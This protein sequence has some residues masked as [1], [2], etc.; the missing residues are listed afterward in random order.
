MSEW[1]PRHLAER[2]DLDAFKAMTAGVPVFDDPALVKRKS[3]DFFWFSPIL[4]EQL[5]HK[6]AD[7]VAQPETEAQVIA[8]ARACTKLRIPLTVRGAGSGTYGQGVPLYGG[9][10]LDMT[11]LDRL[12]WIKPD[13]VRA[14]A[15]HRILHLDQEARKLGVELRMHPSTKRTATIGGYFTGGSGGVGS[16]TYGGLREPGNLVAA[17]VVTM[18]E[19]PRILELRGADAALVNRT[20]GTTGIV[21]EVELPLSPAP[22]WHDIALPFEDKMQAVRFATALAGESAIAK[23][24]VS[25]AHHRIAESFE[26]LEAALAGQNSVLSMVDPAHLEAV[27]ALAHSFGSDIAYDRDSASMEDDPEAVPIYEYSW[28]HATLHA[29]KRDK[30]L[31][32]LQTLFA[33]PD[34]NDKIARMIDIFGDEVMLRLE[35]IRYDGDLAA[36]GAQLIPFRSAERIREII[37][38]HEA[39]DIPVANPHVYT[40]EDGS[41]HK[42]VPGDQ[43][44]FKRVVDPHGLLNPGKMTG[45][46]P[47]A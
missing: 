37:D 39:H 41:R 30:S 25:V 3:R 11:G 16:V 8:V 14:Q 35:Y 9:V 47:I 40:L 33:G 7:L 28:G 12:V 44:S 36:N 5:K 29:R 27:R 13:G 43:L 32:Y 10:V 22:L 31:T 1:K 26:T 19:E 6:T 20:Y 42:R 17:R 4:N 45:Y 46:Q 24:L 38:T 2:Y 18:E 23:K 15:G 34:M 21:T